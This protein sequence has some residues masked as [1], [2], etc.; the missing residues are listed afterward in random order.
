MN[1]GHENVVGISTKKK[2]RTRYNF[3]KRSKIENAAATSGTKQRKLKVDAENSIK[4][5][6][7]TQLT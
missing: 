3:R 7:A 2:G 1:S 5:L 4:T 6:R